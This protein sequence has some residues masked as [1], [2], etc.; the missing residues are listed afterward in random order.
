MIARTTSEHTLDIDGRPVALRLRRNARARRLI[1]RPDSHRADGAVGFVVT[2]P[3][4][5][6]AAEALQWAAGQTAWIRR[7]LAKL[8]DRVAFVDGAVIPLADVEHQIRHQPTARR[9]VWAAD[10]V[11]HV[12]GRPEHLARRVGD[13]LKAEAKQ[14][15]TELAGA[16]TAQLGV[17]YGRIT[18]R[19]T[20]SRWGSCAVNGNLNF[21]WRLVMA[22]AFVFDY[23]VAH[24]VAH[25]LE[26]NHGPGFWRL[27]DSL[28]A[29]TERARAW[30]N[31]YGPGLHRYG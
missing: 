16:K 28:T 23:V 11:I 27:V 31:S 1:L 6:D 21:S 20:K 10:C 19:D 8:P 7:H 4:A 22:P 3:D 12:S 18:V 26:H 13:W 9:G 14:R 17:N 2:L 30:L 29:E 15:I 5:A 24:E 25:L